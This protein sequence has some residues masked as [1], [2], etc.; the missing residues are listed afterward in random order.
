MAARGPGGGPGPGGGGGGGG[1]GRRFIQ[2][3]AFQRFARRAAVTL[4]FATQLR[5]MPSQHFSSP[6]SCAP[7]C[8][9]T[10]LGACNSWRRATPGIVTLFFARVL[11]AIVWIYLSRKTCVIAYASPICC[12]LRAILGRRIFLA[13]GRGG[14]PRTRE[15][16]H[17][18]RNTILRTSLAALPLSRPPPSASFLSASFRRWFSRCCCGCLLCHATLP[19]HTYTRP[20]T[21]HGHVIAQ[22]QQSV[23][24][25]MHVNTS[26]RTQHGQTDENRT[27]SMCA[28]VVYWFTQSF[29]LRFCALSTHACAS[30]H[31]T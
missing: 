17:S 26:R 21:G 8:Q 6:P 11:G 20:Q 1:G 31:S 5:A 13:S 12:G 4:F 19:A 16:V 30:T 28:S 9:N 29:I 24:A 23:P 2:S 25:L 3:T 15:A 7:C 22:P 14:H 18:Q 27:A 10:F